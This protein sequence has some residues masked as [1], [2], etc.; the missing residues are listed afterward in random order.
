MTNN[1]F[2]SAANETLTLTTKC[3]FSLM[4]NDMESLSLSYQY[5]R[6]ELRG[7]INLKTSNILFPPKFFIAGTIGH[8]LK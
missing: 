5:H 6:Q 8:N 4:D 3:Y 2:F 7:V 1:S